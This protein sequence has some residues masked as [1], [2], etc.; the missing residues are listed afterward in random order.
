[1]TETTKEIFEKYE[2]RKTKRQKKKFRKYIKALAS[3]QG[4]TVKEDKGYLG[5]RNVIIGD[6]DRAKVIYTAHYDTCPKLPF[7][8]FITPK[9][10]LIY[11]LYQMLLMVFIFA[12]MILFGV[13]VGVVLGVIG[14][15]VELPAVVLELATPFV[16]LGTL[17]LLLC[18]PANKHTANDNTSGVTTLVDIMMALPQG[19]REK[20]AFVFFDLEEMGMWGS[21][22]FASKHK[23]SLA[24]KLV[25]NFDCVSDGQTILFAVNKSAREF[26]P[27]LKRAFQPTDDLQVN[28]ATRGCFYPSDNMAVPCGVGVAALKKS[29]LLKILYMDRIHTKKDTVY[30]EENIAYLKE[31]SIRLLKEF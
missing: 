28:I 20:V 10:F 5:A 14:S 12:L 23:K 2:V 6:P 15:F 17:F 22:G 1:M 3:E 13:V 26:V 16:M 19:E 30:R 27:L 11:L 21:M 24:K 8:N 7:P 9:N 29:K 25:L 4:Y 31:G 18:G